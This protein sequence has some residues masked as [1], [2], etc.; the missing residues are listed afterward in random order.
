MNGISKESFLDAGDA[1]A[2]DGLLYD[3]LNNIYK[4]VSFRRT[5][6]IALVSGALG[7]ASVL[8]VVSFPKVAKAIIQLCL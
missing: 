3:M 6:T 2:R 8:F 4:Q 7:G 5:V 1:K